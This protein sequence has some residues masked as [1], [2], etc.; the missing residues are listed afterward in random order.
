M[1]L[2][3]FLILR[4]RGFRKISCKPRAFASPMRSLAEDAKEQRLKKIHLK[5]SASEDKTCNDTCSKRSRVINAH[6]HIYCLPFF[7]ECLF[8]KNAIRKS[9][10]KFSPARNLRPLFPGFPESVDSEFSDAG[11]FWRFEFSCTLLV[12]C[13]CSLSGST[14]SCTISSRHPRD[15]DIP[16]SQVFTRLKILKIFSRNLAAR[17]RSLRG[18]CT[19]SRGSRARG[20]RI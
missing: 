13:R 20:L 4:W 12:S 11:S 1:T 14:C 5:E 7:P 19:F 15:L 6:A 18:E 2:L 10:L 3:F 8:S 16:R 9:K 17:W